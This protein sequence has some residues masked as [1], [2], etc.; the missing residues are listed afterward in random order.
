MGE[1]CRPGSHRTSNG[2]SEQRQL[3][4]LKP[5]QG[6]RGPELTLP[7]ARVLDDLDAPWQRL[8]GS[9]EFLHDLLVD[10]LGPGCAGRGVSPW[11]VGALMRTQGAGGSRLESMGRTSQRPEVGRAWSSPASQ[12]G[13]QGSAHVPSRVSPSLLGPG[14]LLLPEQHWGVSPSYG[15]KMAPAP[16]LWGLLHPGWPI[17]A[18]GSPQQP[19][20]MLYS[21][22]GIP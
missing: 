2:D 3:L 15:R 13:L 7:P 5:R 8:E 19:N 22:P 6:P 21:D 20:T 1:R 10:L 9:A 14:P 16:R 17:Y 12:G 18:S 11:A 4:L